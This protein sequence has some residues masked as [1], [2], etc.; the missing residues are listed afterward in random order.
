MDHL[1]ALRQ[2]YR[3]AVALEQQ[4]WGQYCQQ[5]AGL[6]LAERNAQAGAL[7]EASERAIVAYRRLLLYSGCHN[8]TYVR[9]GTPA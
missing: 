1:S 9:E 3:Q 2:E 4:L 8:A 7:A 5:P 6:S